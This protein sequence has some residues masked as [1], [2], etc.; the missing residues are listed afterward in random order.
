MVAIAN[1]SVGKF[2]SDAHLQLYGWVDP[3]VNV[4]TN[5]NKPG[6]NAPI[7]YA[8]TPNTWSLDQVVLYLDRFPDNVQTD[9]IDWGLR[10]SGIYG[11]N[12]RYTTSYGLASYQLLKHNNINGYDFPMEWL[13]LFIPQV[14]HGLNIRVGRYISVPDIEAQLAPNNYMYTHSL[15]YATDN[16]TN[17]GIATTWAITKQLFVQLALSVGTETPVWHVGQTVANPNPNPLFP[18]RT[19]KRDPGSQ[20][21]GTACIR[22]TWN[23]GADD[24]MPCLDGWNTGIWGYNNLQW[25][26]FTFYHKFNDHWHNSFEFYN[27]HQNKV[28]NASNPTLFPTSQGPETIAAIYA[29]GGTPFSPPYIT[30]NAPNLAHCKNTAALDCRATGMGLVDYINYSPEP[31]DNYSLR[32]EYYADNQG[33]RFGVP[34]DY[35]EFTVGWQ[36]WFSPQIETRPE[37]GYYRSVDADAFNANFSRSGRAAA[38]DKNHTYFGATDLIFHW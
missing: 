27:E 36:H 6:G 3:G 4:S 11:E 10:L 2:M 18:G 37:F 14:F 25:Y 28:P 9:H 19:F 21:T 29:N 15:T 7:A 31:L 20:P 5:T 12:Y 38:P 22:Y 33:Q 30:G 1:T 34:T 17:T 26:G 32:G 23:N 13:E 24:I 35:Y 8:Y 16:Y